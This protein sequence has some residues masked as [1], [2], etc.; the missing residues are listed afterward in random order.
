MPFPNRSLYLAV[1]VA[2]T[3]VS[4]APVP[5]GNE[6][7]EVHPVKIQ[8]VSSVQPA[9]AHQV[10]RQESV[11]SS[12][13]PPLLSTG[14]LH[15]LGSGEGLSAGDQFTIP[16][17][18]DDHS[19]L[20][21]PPGAGNKPCPCYRCESGGQARHHL[22]FPKTGLIC[23]EDGQNCESIGEKLQHSHHHHH[24]L[25]ADHDR[26]DRGEEH[27]Q[28][29]TQPNDDD[30]DFSSGE[31]LNEVMYD[32]D[33]YDL[34]GSHPEVVMM[35][36]GEK[37][38]TLGDHPESTMAKRDTEN[39]LVVK[40]TDR[41]AVNMPK[42]VGAVVHA[43]AKEVRLQDEEQEEVQPSIKPCKRDSKAA[44][45]E[46]EK[47]GGEPIKARSAPEEGEQKKELSSDVLTKRADQGKSGELLASKIER[48]SVEKDGANGA[49]DRTATTM[50]SVKLDQSKKEEY[51]D[52]LERRDDFHATH[53]S[54]TKNKIILDYT[55][56]NDAIEED[57]E[58]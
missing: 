14:S 32:D 51:D 11:P 20:S 4:A 26:Q 37:E 36:R 30:D 2:L 6:V 48:T 7:S 41:H 46:G 10:I 43:A 16:Y 57:D 50:S 45:S 33:D 38:S 24:H 42:D 49:K 21:F 58:E 54:L 23:D 22:Y 19:L 15:L 31:P 55:Y 18:Q 3:I 29:A 34:I 39:T 40:M 12:A 5:F 9:E 1:L 28:P 13:L 56:D 27:R 47:D 52:G 25:Q 35:G 17:G 8:I 53:P 44:T